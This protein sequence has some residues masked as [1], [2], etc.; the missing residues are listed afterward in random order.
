MLIKIGKIHDKVFEKPEYFSV[1]EIAL[2]QG[3]D[4][5]TVRRH[6]KKGI[7]LTKETKEKK[8]T[9]YPLKNIISHCL[10]MVIQVGFRVIIK[11]YIPF[12]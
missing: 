6:L 5:K 10:M 8:L 4:P 2:R 7:F 3:V 9:G 12:I 1:G 11:T